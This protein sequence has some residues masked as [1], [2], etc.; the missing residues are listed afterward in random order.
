MANVMV[1]AE[2]ARPT[3]RG[4]RS[5]FGTGALSPC[6]VSGKRPAQPEEYAT[7][8]LLTRHTGFRSIMRNESNAPGPPTTHPALPRASGAPARL[9]L[10]PKGEHE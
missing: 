8:L 10:A 5:R 3:L 1:G 7:S 2:V 4:A 9:T 6:G